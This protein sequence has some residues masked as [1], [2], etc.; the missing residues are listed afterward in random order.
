VEDRRDAELDERRLAFIGEG[1]RKVGFVALDWVS[2]VVEDDASRAHPALGD[3]G[4]ELGLTV[5]N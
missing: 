4:I 2:L 3:R 5:A 1:A